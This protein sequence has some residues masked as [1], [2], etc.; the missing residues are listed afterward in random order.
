MYI[1]KRVITLTT[2]LARTY[3]LQ[4]CTQSPNLKTI[5]AKISLI[6]VSA[7]HSDLKIEKSVMKFFIRVFAMFLTKKDLVLRL[8]SPAFLMDMA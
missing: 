6:Q 5:S 1:C 2:F 4:A 7:L 3:T 8:N